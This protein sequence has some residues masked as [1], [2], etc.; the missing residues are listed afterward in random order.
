MLMS[1][2]R[3][4]SIGVFDSGVGGLSVW[5]ELVHLLPSE[6]TIYVGDQVHCPYGRR[7]LAEIRLLSEGIVRFLLRHGAKIIVVACNTASAAALYGLRERFDVPIVGMEPAVKPAAERTVTG[8]VGVMATPATFQGEPFARLLRRFASGVTVMQSA[9]PGLVEKIEAGE[10]EGPSVEGLVR[11][12]LQPMLDGGVDVVVLGCT[13]YPLI[14][15]V[16]ERVVGET[17]AVIDP[18][19]AVATQVERV[20]AAGG[21]MASRGREE[22]HVLYTTG[23]LEPFARLVG[24]MGVQG[25][26]RPAEW[27]DVN[28][29]VADLWALPSGDGDRGT[30]GA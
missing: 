24:L 8:R 14:R 6:H 3:Q 20:L 25:Q 29:S 11:A 4:G 17:I 2:S 7:A 18:A 12:C 28:E 22:Q 27:R 13:H 30:V 23:R 10:L 5:K 15:P 9:C 21:M 19:R 26:F 1:H 16:I